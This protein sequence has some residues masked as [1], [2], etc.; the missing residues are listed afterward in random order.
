M[1][2]SGLSN[3]QLGR[4]DIAVH[5]MTLSSFRAMPRKGHL[6]KVKKV[7]GYIVK[8]KDATIR[9]KTDMPSTDD[10]DFVEYMIGREH[11]TQVQKKSI[12]EIFQQLEVFLSCR[13]PIRMPISIMTCFQGK[14]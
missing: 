4:F 3:W 9:Y 11:F 14:R 5:V 12:Q 1:Q 7:Y 8:F 13:Q 6:E 10:M 2:C